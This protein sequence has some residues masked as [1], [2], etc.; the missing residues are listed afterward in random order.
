MQNAIHNE[1]GI[2]QHMDQLGLYPHHVVIY[3]HVGLCILHLLST[4]QPK[5]P[6]QRKTQSL[7]S[8]HILFNF[9]HSYNHLCS[10]YQFTNPFTHAPIHPL[11]TS[12]SNPSIYWSTYKVACLS[13]NSF[14]ISPHKPTNHPLTHIYLPR[15]FFFQSLYHFL[16]FSSMFIIV[17]K[18]EH[19]S[20]ERI[21]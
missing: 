10:I 11:I 19:S 2:T 4:N 17:I 1:L 8:P 16:F 9:S 13:M 6:Y 18:M 3:T 7:I 12:S 21:T 15:S 20:V 14:L 5:T